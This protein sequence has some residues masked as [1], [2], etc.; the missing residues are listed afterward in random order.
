[1]TETKHTPAPGT[2][3]ITP[4]WTGLMPAFIAVLE[5]G[6]ETGKDMARQELFKLA[7]AVDHT[8]TDSLR[9]AAPELLAALEDCV[10]DLQ[11]WADDH[12]E[13]GEPFLE[14]E[15]ALKKARAAIAKAEGAP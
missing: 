3:D 1:M 14:T 11:N 9:K 8:N 13:P 15:D 2:I 12:E 10:I 7:Q 5:G 6:G 4:T